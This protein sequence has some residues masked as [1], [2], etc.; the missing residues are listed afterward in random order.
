MYRAWK[1]GAAGCY[2][3]RRRIRL[4]GKILGNNLWWTTW[5]WV[6]SSAVHC[7]TSCPMLAA[8]E[9]FTN[10]AK[11]ETLDTLDLLNTRYMVTGM[12]FSVKCGYSVIF[13]E[14]IYIRLRF[15]HIQPKLVSIDIQHTQSPCWLFIHRCIVYREIQS[16]WTMH[17]DLQPRASIPKKKKKKT[18]NA[19]APAVNSKN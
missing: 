18:P 10:N 13:P 1:I 6:H 16:L 12:Y 11:I 2:I 19:A 15:F 4:P 17:R 14:Y 5:W 8:A 9:R 3:P 7:Q